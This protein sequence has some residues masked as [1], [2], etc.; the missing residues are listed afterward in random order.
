[1]IILLLASLALCSEHHK[2][3]SH[4][5][6]YD[7]RTTISPLIYNENYSPDFYSGQSYE[8]FTRVLGQADN[9]GVTMSNIKNEDHKK[10]KQ[11]FKYM[12]IL[13]RD[14]YIESKWDKVI[15]ETLEMVDFDQ[16]H[17]KNSLYRYLYR[18]SKLSKFPSIPMVFSSILETNNS[19]REITDQFMGAMKSSG[20]LGPEPDSRLAEL[21]KGDLKQK[22]SEQIL[23]IDEILNTKINEKTLNL[24]NPEVCALYFLKGFIKIFE[25]SN[26]NLI[27]DSLATSIFLLYSS[28]HLWDRNQLILETSHSFVELMEE[29]K[30]DHARYLCFQD[31]TIAESE[32]CPL[33]LHKENL[34]QSRLVEYGIEPE[35]SEPNFIYRYRD[36]AKNWI[37][38]NISGAPR[39]G[40]KIVRTFI[41]LK[42]YIP[43]NSILYKHFWGNNA[44]TEYYGL[45]DSRATMKDRSGEIRAA[46]EYII[47]RVDDY[48]EDTTAPYIYYYNLF[49]YKTEVALISRLSNTQ[50]N[51]D[52]NEL[53]PL[54]KMVEALNHLILKDGDTIVIDIPNHSE[55]K[56][57]FE[58]LK[59]LIQDRME[60]MSMGIEV[61]KIPKD[62]LKKIISPSGIDFNKIVKLGTNKRYSHD[63]WE[64]LFLIC[65]FLVFILG[66]VILYSGE[67]YHG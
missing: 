26:I 48:T 58:A 10:V 22:A 39:I 52:A 12:A 2:Y 24:S 13:K 53:T 50:I 9:F 46:M 6:L 66:A 63:I 43:G 29:L 7:I 8:L 37:I 17:N 44:E 38:K 1:M 67:K 16:R 15:E 33:E 3:K 62:I 56:C 64:S 40:E 27:I 42:S 60:S 31:F 45:F 5:Q 35:E 11:L 54:D 21:E 55:C 61:S 19:I 4:Q 30:K 59:T 18:I 23:A 65:L 28:Y 32:K 14:E 36:R 25:F 20:V 57:K 41:D 34:L 49:I 51:C 47:N